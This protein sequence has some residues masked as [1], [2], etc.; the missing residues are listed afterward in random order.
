[1]LTGHLKYSSAIPG[2]FMAR[3]LVEY[4]LLLELSDG[5]TVTFPQAHAIYSPIIIQIDLP[6]EKIIPITSSEIDNFDIVGLSSDIVIIS[7]KPGERV[8]SQDLFIALSYFGNYSLM[9]NLIPFISI[10]V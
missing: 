4:Y 2:N 6:S 3:D 5:K 10:P 7:P 1:M 8:K 9:N